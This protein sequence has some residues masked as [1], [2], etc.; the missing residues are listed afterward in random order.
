M[1]TPGATCCTSE[2]VLRRSPARMRWR[3]VRMARALIGRDVPSRDCRVPPS[4][5][6]AS[7]A[8]ISGGPCPRQ[9]PARSSD[10]GTTRSRPVPSSRR[11]P[12]P[13]RRSRGSSPASWST[14]SSP[15]K[16]RS[17]R[18][19]ER[20]RQIGPGTYVLRAGDTIIENPELEHYGAN[21]GPGVVELIS[22]TLYPEGA[23]PSTPLELASPAP[24]VSPEPVAS[25]AG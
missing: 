20:P 23:A 3:P 24:A 14:R 19:T 13:G 16:G 9:R 15:A 8:R 5:S 11:I 4:R 12:I 7:R 21:R 2:R 18:W 6:R 25:P 17:S 10:S 1:M 22:A